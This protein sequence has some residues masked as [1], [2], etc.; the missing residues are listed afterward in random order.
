MR[1][2]VDNRSLLALHGASPNFMSALSWAIGA[3][4][5]A[6]AGVLLVAGIGLVYLQLTLLI[7]TAYAA[8]ILGKLE[9]LPLTFLGSLI[10]GL[11]T[12][13]AI[14][15]LPSSSY[16]NG[17]RIGLPAIFLFLVL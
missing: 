6:L 10:I 1:A 17:L 5:A 8:A 9:N 16:Y 3:S 13:Y 11:A 15:Y 2:V 4:L 14:G 7:I 12:S